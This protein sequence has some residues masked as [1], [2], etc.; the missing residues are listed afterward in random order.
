VGGIKIGCVAFTSDAYKEV[1]PIL[2]MVIG[3]VTLREDRGDAEET[4]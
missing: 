4:K 2:G 3:L 1:A